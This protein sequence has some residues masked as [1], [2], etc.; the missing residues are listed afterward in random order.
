[1]KFENE[2][3]L[4]TIVFSDGEAHIYSATEEWGGCGLEEETITIVDE[5]DL[6]KNMKQDLTRDVKRL[7][8]EKLKVEKAIKVLRG[9]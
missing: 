7:E 4:I 6:L 5:I 2:P 1:M 3:R 9:N 8:N